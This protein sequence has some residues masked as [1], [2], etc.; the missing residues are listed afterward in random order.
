[1]L[2]LALLVPAVSI[3]QPAKRDDE[4][5]Q[6]YQQERAVCLAGTGP[7]DR[8]T[9][10]KEAGAALAESRRQGLTDPGQKAASN[11][12]QRCQA[13]PPADRSACLER[14]SG[15]GSVTG[16][17]ASGG[18]LRELRTTVPA[19]STPPFMPASAASR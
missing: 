7:Q 2:M 12:R 14:M 4:A 15:K 18:I 13:L 3:A 10:L 1:M 9:C 19:A 11:L 8:E 5:Q 17:V 6:R 16:S